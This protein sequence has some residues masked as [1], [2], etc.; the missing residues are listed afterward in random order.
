MKSFL[1]VLLTAIAILLAP[2]A[3]AV[4]WYRAET[5]HFIVYS[6]DSESDTIEFVQDLE[7][8]D[9]VLR[10][11]TGVGIDDGSLPES[12]KVTVFRFGETR[13]MSSLAAGNQHSGIGGFFIGRAHG[14]VA[15]V[16]RQ[17]D[18]RRTRRSQRMS[19]RAMDLDPKAV[20]A[21]EYVHYFMYQHRDAPYPLWYSEG[22]AELFSNV[23]FE[24]DHFVIGDVPP[25]RSAALATLSV[26]LQ[27]TFDPPQGRALT[28]RVYGHG[29]M[30]AS[31]LNLNSERRGQMG[32]YMVAIGEVKPPMEAAEEAFGDLEVLRQELE[33]FR[34]GRARTLRVPYAV[35]ADPEV[36]IRR[37]SEDEEARMQLMIA[38]KAGVNEDEARDLVGQARSLVA[39]YPDS[40]AV[41]LA[42]T[43]A[44][45]DARNYDEAENLATRVLAIDP[46][47]TMAAIYR[48][49]V[50]LRRSFTDPVQIAEAR[51]RFAAANRLE[52]DHAYPLYGYY[53]TYLLDDG[54]EVT[55]Q[56]KMA[57]E[58]A[59][60]YAPFD[61]GVRRAMTHML[62]TED[63]VEE[64][65]VV[66]AR[67][68][69]GQSSYAC[70]VRGKLDEFR[71]GEREA[72]LEEI[73]PDHPGEHLTEAEREAERDARHPEIRE[74]GCEVD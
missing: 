47:S 51:S 30:I 72:L 46:Q 52:V 73:R 17:A 36:R 61:S 2:P 49:D 53:L 62:L 41:L 58:A 23:Q 5:A 21:H 74:Y 31:H 71:S 44:E 55:D 12:S 27:D 54:T 6:E 24:D 22:F 57:L 65:Q 13:D 43:E 56:A 42:A 38:S 67:Y 45:F 64:A 3:H 48:A 50:A 39:R 18:R 60:A 26:D 11:M 25:W 34:T 9:E 19:E 59:F 16:P 33:E 4:D 15:F 10:L 7:R 28:D 14:S 70:M 8:L 29:W 69:S 35:D 63:R 37:L 20:L 68:F 32:R 66:G 1:A 40:P